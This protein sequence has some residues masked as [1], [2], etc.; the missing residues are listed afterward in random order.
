MWGFRGPEFH[1]PVLQA[2][3]R[4]EGRVMVQSLKQC[5]V[6]KSFAEVCACGCV[7]L[8]TNENNIGRIRFQN[9]ELKSKMC[10]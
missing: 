7:C 10:R 6:A 2:K 4:N 1:R 8:C 9:E 5:D 3:G